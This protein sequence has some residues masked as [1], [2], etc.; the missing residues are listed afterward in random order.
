VGVGATVTLVPRFD[1]AQVL[2][3]I[4]RD[5]V[6]VFEGVTTMYAAMLGA[7]N[8]GQVDVSSVLRR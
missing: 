6:T 8:R 3:V 2:R 5:R 7:P 4:A 1:P